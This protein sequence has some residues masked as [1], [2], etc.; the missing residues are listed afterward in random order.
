MRSRP[1]ARRR[2]NASS[3]R[4]RKRSNP[5]ADKLVVFMPNPTRRHKNARRRRKNAHSVHHYRRRRNPVRAISHHSRRRHYRR[6]N[7]LQYKSAFVDAIWAG[8]GAVGTRTLTNV[9]L[10]SKNQ[11]AMGYFANG[12]VAVGL[13]LVGEKFSDQA[14]NMLLVGGLV[15]TL[16]RIVQEKLMPGGAIAQQL[17]LQ[18]LGDAS[19]ALGDF[20]KNYAVL[21]SYSQADA[22]GNM[23]ND[24][25]PMYQALQPYSPKPKAAGMSGYDSVTNEPAVARYVSRFG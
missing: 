21:P 2:T 14:G 25:Q 23:V 22:Q 8:A 3:A 6:K 12:A 24:W 5:G 19:F 4:K 16:L 17:S 18:G 13:G 1:K 10:G 15:A 11:G 7:P 9:V 20:I